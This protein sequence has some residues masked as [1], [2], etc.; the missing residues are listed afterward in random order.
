MNFIKILQKKPTFLILS[1][2]VLLIFSSCEKDSDLF[3]MAIEQDIAETIEDQEAKEESEAVEEPT[4]EEPI[5]EDN[6]TDDFA[7]ELKAFPTAEGFGKYTTGGRGGVVYTVTNLNDSGAGSLRE[8][9]EKTSGARTVVFGVSGTINLSNTIYISNGD[10]TIAGQTSPNGVLINGGGLYITAGNIIIRNIRLINPINGVEDGLSIR[11]FGTDKIENIILDHISVSKGVD[12]NIGISGINANTVIK[13]VTLQNSI[14]SNANYGVLVSTSVQNL[15]IYKNFFVFNNDR[16]PKI[17]SPL[18]LD[19]L[20]TPL[21]AEV[22]NNI[23]YGNPNMGEPTYGLKIDYQGN[24]FKDYNGMVFEDYQSQI[25]ELSR[26]GDPNGVQKEYSQIYLND[27][28]LINPGT[29]KNP[30]YPTRILEADNVSQF[31]VSKPLSSSSIPVMDSGEVASDLVSSIGA[32]PNDSYD[33]AFI[34][35]YLSG[36]SNPNPSLPDLSGGTPYQ[37]NDG[38]GMDDA[39]ERSR[40]L[41]P[42]VQDHNGDDDGDGYTNLEEFLNYLMP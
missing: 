28:V 18:G 35:A 14:I 39:W 26:D 23:S 10:L 21:R 31:K 20:N 38:D 42:T 29:S 11:N 8:F 27:N 16:N 13:N 40:G 12:E 19:E 6:S 5:P 33:R 17:G 41:D 7:T 30:T 1:L 2:L 34:N 24:V 9:V 37:D 4:E 22:V 36:A 25:Y 3:A 15:S 32:I